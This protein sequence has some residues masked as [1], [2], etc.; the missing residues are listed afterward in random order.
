MLQGNNDP[1]LVPSY[2]SRDIYS[3][4]IANAVV[5][6]LWRVTLELGIRP[7]YSPHAALASRLATTVKRMSTSVGYQNLKNEYLTISVTSAY[8]H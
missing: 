5:G 6:G 2:G 4:K 8:V 1:S 7:C 3:F